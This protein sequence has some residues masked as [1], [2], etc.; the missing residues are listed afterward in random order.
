MKGFI[1]LTRKESGLDYIEEDIEEYTWPWVVSIDHIVSYSD[2]LISVDNQ[3]EEYTVME[4]ED[5]ITA[6]ILN[7]TA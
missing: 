1:K 4:T 2:G 3:E 5:E 7:A 6:A